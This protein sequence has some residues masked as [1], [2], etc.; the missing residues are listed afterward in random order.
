ML[1]QKRLA[2]P[3]VL[4]KAC[5]RWVPRAVTPVLLLKFWFRQLLGDHPERDA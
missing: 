5:A 1:P 4:K 2:R 3:H